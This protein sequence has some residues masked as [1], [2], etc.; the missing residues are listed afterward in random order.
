MNKI[1]YI[2]S[3]YRE[4]K[5][6]TVAE[7]KEYARELVKWAINNGYTPI[8]P[9]LY[10]TEVLNDENPEERETG[11]RLGLELL[12]A[13]SVIVIGATYGISEGMHAEIEEAMRLGLV[14][15]KVYKIN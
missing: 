8:C 12:S 11:R 9:H 13:C 6:A 2:C 5:R 15:D 4:S 3:P 10:I 1:A 7:H 14:F